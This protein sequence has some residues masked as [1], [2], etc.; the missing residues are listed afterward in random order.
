MHNWHKIGCCNALAVEDMDTPPP[1]TRLHRFEAVQSDM[2]VRLRHRLLNRPCY[3]RLPGT[4]RPVEENDG[5][6]LHASAYSVLC[7]PYVSSMAQRR[8]QHFAP[9]RSQDATAPRTPPSVSV[10]LPAPT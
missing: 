3:A 5:A 7:S 10:T 4:G 1:L 8:A 6:Y 2:Q 9:L